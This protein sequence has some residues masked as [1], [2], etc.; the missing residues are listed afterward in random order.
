MEQLSLVS[1]NVFLRP[2]LIKSNESD[3]KESRAR[4]MLEELRRFDVVC[5]QEAFDNFSH[6]RFLLLELAAKAGFHYFALPDPC[7]FL[8][9]YLIESGLVILSRFPIVHSEFHEYPQGVQSDS[10]AKKGVLFARILVHERFL[11]VFTTHTQASYFDGDFAKDG[12]AFCRRLLQLQSLKRFIDKTLEQFE[13]K[14]DVNILAGD[15]NVNSRA[16]SYPLEDILEVFPSL[17]ES[18]LP[19]NLCNEYDLLEAVFNPSESPYRMVDVLLEKHGRHL[20]TYGDAEEVDGLFLP[21]DPILTDAGEQCSM[22]RLDYIFEIFPKHK[23]PSA[24]F[25]EASIEKFIVKNKPFKQLSDHYGVAV[26]LRFLEDSDQKAP[27]E[28]KPVAPVSQAEKA[29]TASEK[30]EPSF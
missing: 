26:Q 21:L 2:Y 16:K 13:T 1:Y 4:L 25:L 29:L 24:E 12:P 20:V 22:Q 8:D 11:N 30:Q 3:Y 14:G 19:C 27:T 10:V 9:G 17:R 23:S 6:R 15:L 18:E 7:W 28:S 5:L